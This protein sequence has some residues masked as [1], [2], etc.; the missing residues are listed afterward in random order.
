MFSLLR[1]G[2]WVM[3]PLGICSIVGLA[4]VVERFVA[5]RRAVVMDP[6]ILAL[7]REY[8]E[9]TSDEKA[10]Q[11]CQ[12]IGGPFARIIEEVIQ[13]RHLEHA[14]AIE[15]M[16]AVG[17]AQMGRLERGLTLL[18]IIAGASPLLGLLGTV[19]GMI[20]MF[21]AVTAQGLGD[22]QVLS[23]GIAKALITTMVG[24]T[25]AIPALAFHSWL[26]RRAEDLAI[27]I[28]NHATSLI[29]KLQAFER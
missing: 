25:V 27:E 3:F 29:A 5:L 4:I 2:G 15:M 23:G 18:E 17:R 13:T 1:Q 9:R 20:S 16:H 28:Q 14:Q 22:P 12:R 21:Q 24:L 26:S 19:L 6:R 10:R 8:S 7:V 11:L